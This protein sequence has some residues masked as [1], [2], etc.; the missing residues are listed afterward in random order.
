[1]VDGGTNGTKGVW[2]F[3][4]QGGAPR[5]MVRNLE[6]LDQPV[7]IT[8]GHKDIHL[9]NRIPGIEGMDATTEADFRRRVYRLA[10]NLLVPCITDQPIPDPCAIASDPLTE[11]LYVYCGRQ[12]RSERF[13]RRLVRLRRA[14]SPNH[15]TAS[16][17]FS[18]FR[19]P[20]ISGV[21][22]SPD[23]QWLMLTEE[24]GP[25]VDM[26]FIYLFQRRSLTIAGH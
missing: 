1:M 26:S 8:F 22:I 5:Q 25:G 7:D 18:G 9:V 19:I 24:G 3:S 12:L 4:I 17:V 6:L 21:D 13:H 16:E 20:T 2:R 23:G 14:A 11:D 10:S 15:F